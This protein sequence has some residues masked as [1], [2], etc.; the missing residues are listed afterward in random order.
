MFRD[1]FYK[2][3]RKLYI[4]S[5][6]V[7]VTYLLFCS[8][9]YVKIGKGT[10]IA[11]ST[12]VDVDNQGSFIISDRCRLHNYGK[13]AAL[14]GNIS[15]G[16]GTTIGD[17]ATFLSGGLISIG[18]NVMFADNIKIVA[19]QHNYEDITKPISAQ[20]T[21]PKKVNVGNNCWIGINVTIIGDVDIGEHCVIAA[22]SVVTKSIPAY[23][24][25]AGVPAKVVKKYCFENK[26][27][28]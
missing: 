15:I 23:S 18:N 22:G 6:K 19:F 1:I 17:Y 2:L 21:I 11:P 12:N 13:I 4:T 14:G 16:S 7:K 27:W 24:V 8:P 3:K 9:G 5:S 20:S 10:L 26:R 28:Q 25:A